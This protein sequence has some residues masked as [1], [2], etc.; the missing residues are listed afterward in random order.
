MAKTQAKL[1]NLS[2]QDLLEKERELLGFNMTSIIG[3]SRLK[4]ET[5]GYKSIRDINDVL[6]SQGEVKN[7]KVAAVIT[8]IEAKTSKAGN[9]FYWITITDDWHTIKL[10]CSENS[11]RD[12]QYDLIKG[13]CVLFNINIRNDFVTFDRCKMIDNIPFKSGYIMSIHLPYGQWTEEFS[14]FLANELDRTIRRGTVG[15]F[16][17][18]YPLDINIDPSYELMNRIENK[19]GVK[20]T[21]EVY[22]DY[23]FGEANKYLKYMED[24]GY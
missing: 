3:E 18:K 2:R 15:V 24:N 21:I 4:I 22:E 19:F 9:Y 5:Y 10:Y 16:M 17:R 1:K 23:I 20:C 11:F 6:L 7:L 12:M 13:R 8:G 14:K